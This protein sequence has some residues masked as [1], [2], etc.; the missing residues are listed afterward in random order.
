[1][2][3][4]GDTSILPSDFDTLKRACRC[5]LS[6]PATLDQWAVLLAQATRQAH[7]KQIYRAPLLVNVEDF[8]RWCERLNVMPC[9]DALRAYVIIQRRERSA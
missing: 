7:D 3:D 5:D 4:L 9:L 1:M 2:H 6:F 8:L